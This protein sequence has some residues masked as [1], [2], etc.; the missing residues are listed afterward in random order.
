MA[1]FYTR[2]KIAVGGLHQCKDGGAQ[3][4]NDAFD[5]QKFS[6]EVQDFMEAFN[7]AK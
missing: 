1:V 3:G 6:P 2:P 5:D 7:G 4:F